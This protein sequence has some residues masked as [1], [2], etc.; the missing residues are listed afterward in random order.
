MLM[1]KNVVAFLFALNA[2]FA[3]SAYGGALD[4]VGMPW[5]QTPW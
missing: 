1:N 5:G 4:P 3:A 2:L